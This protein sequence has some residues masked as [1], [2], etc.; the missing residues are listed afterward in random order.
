MPV[1]AVPTIKIPS[2]FDKLKEICKGGITGKFDPI[3]FYV[4]I[5]SLFLPILALL[6]SFYV[7][8]FIAIPVFLFMC[9]SP[10]ALLIMAWKIEHMP[11]KV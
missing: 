10:T 11:V 9:I 1:V 5:V 7:S 4:G 2:Q 3:I 6:G 8:I